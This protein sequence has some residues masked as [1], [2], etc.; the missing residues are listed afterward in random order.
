M[1]TFLPSPD[2]VRS[3]RLL[4]NLRLNKQRLEGLQIFGA[5]NNPKAGYTNHP[6]VK[7]WRGHVT[8]LACWYLGPIC[9]ECDRRKIADDKQVRRRIADFA[10]TA[11]AFNGIWPLPWWVGNQAFH[12]SHRRNL[13]FKDIRYAIKFGITQMQDKP[14]YVWPVWADEYELNLSGHAQLMLHGR[15]TKPRFFKGVLN[16]P[17]AHGHRLFTTEQRNG[18]PVMYLLEKP[19]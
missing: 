10:D 9:D 13:A 15:Y 2:P 14:M 8:A 5:L 3:A 6:A 7:M 11:E 12:R 1:Q 19:R 18:V 16:R 17:D 4:D